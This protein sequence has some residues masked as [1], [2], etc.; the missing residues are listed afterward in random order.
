MVL[1]Y[2]LCLIMFIIVF[3]GWSLESFTDWGAFTRLGIYGILM[4]CFE[5]WAIETT[6][7]LSGKN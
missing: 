5:W 4:I 6:I 7:I 2:Y 1:L 3:L